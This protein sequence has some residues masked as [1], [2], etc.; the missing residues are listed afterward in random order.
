MAYSPYCNERGMIE[1]RVL[2][3]FRLTDASGVFE[4]SERPA[5]DRGD[6]WVEYPHRIF[7]ADG[8]RAARVGKTVAH[9]VIDEAA[10]GS[11]VVEKWTLRRH[12]AYPRA[13]AA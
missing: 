12:R 5:G 11:P 13:S 9:V 3:E 4:Y 10:D 2:G 1:P 6:V 7:T 8:D